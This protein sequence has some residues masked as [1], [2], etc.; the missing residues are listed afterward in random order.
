[1]V[2]DSVPLEPICLLGDDRVRVRVRV[3]VMGYV[4]GLGLWF[5]VR[6]MC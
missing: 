4:L 1:M 3:R 2:L 6:V 5:R